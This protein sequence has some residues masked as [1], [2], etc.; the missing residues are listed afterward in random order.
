MDSNSFVYW[1][2]GFFELSGATALNEQQVQVIKEHIALVMTKVTPSTVGAP[3]IYPYL[4]PSPLLDKGWEVTCNTEQAVHVSTDGTQDLNLPRCDCHGIFPVPSG[5][6]LTIPPFPT[7][8]VVVCP[9][10]WKTGDSTGH[11][12]SE[13]KVYPPIVNVKTC[14]S[15]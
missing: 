5:T 3:I 8:S 7:S 1:L 2:N 11:S 15:C 13:Y 14:L 9:N 12:C 6:T 4:A 10:A